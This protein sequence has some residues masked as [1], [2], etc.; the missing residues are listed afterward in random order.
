MKD[1]VSITTALV[2]LAFKTIPNSE[3]AESLNEVFAFLSKILLQSR[4]EVFPASSPVGSALI[5]LLEFLQ[6]KAADLS[7]FLE[8]AAK[9]GFLALCDRLAPSA[10]RKCQLSLA[11]WINKE[12]LRKPGFYALF[13]CFLQCDLMKMLDSNEEALAEQFAAIEQDLNA[14]TDALLS[15]QLE[16]AEAQ[17]LC[18]S[19]QSGQ[20]ICLFLHPRLLASFP[21]NFAL[22]RKLLATVVSC[23]A[24]AMPPALLHEAEQF[25]WLQPEH[26][27]TLAIQLNLQCAQ[28]CTNP[29]ESYEFYSEVIE[30]QCELII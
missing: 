15:L 28:Q 18:A 11:A 5:E 17:H 4:E 7:L 29:S 16:E 25:E 12:Q 23:T 9:P 2:S 3:L 10:V 19:I 6:M 22:H 24:T 20:L 13:G 8:L 14:F 21:E 30:K 27:K 1:A 26:P